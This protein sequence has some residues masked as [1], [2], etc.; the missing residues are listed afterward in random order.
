[1]AG[2]SVQ[3]L[4]APELILREVSRIQLPGT[5]LSDIFGWG[6]AARDPENM[7]G[8][9]VDYQLR[10]GSY[11]VFNAS[12][13]LATGS[14][15][16][17][18]PTMRKPQKVGRVPFTIPRAHE[19]MPLTDEDLVNRRAIGQAVTVVDSMGENY[20]MRQKRYLAQLVAN[21]IEFQTAAMMRGTYTY[22]QQGDELRQGFSGG[23]HT[24][25]FQIPTTNKNQLNGII[26]V[27][28][29]TASTDI[30]TDIMEINQACND[31]TGLGIEHAV[32]NGFTY[33]YFLNN[34]KIKA[35]A[36]TSNTPFQSYERTGPGTYAVVF[37]AIPWLQFH[38]V[39]YSL[40][41][42]DGSAQTDPTRLIANDQVTFF[43]TPSPAW[44]QYLNGGEVI[45]EGPNGTREF[46]TGFYA[47]GYP[48]WE[49][50][51]WNLCTVMNGFPALY[52]PGAIFNADVT[53]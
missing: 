23:D 42:W 32:T 50:S 53:P 21:M 8:N 17:T 10:D 29:A 36:G 16:G 41:I 31:G 15:P 33:G 37:R 45:T 14:V 13:E 4:M 38:V 35:Q 40:S 47:Y 20:I 34:D 2:R 46:R 5:I 39:D 12:R 43:P 1:M 9:M 6:L 24:I 25:D 48:Q 28:W 49:P 27:S 18:P 7:G 19:K 11:D 52:I 22:D 26:G 51:G 44:C 30:P 3:E